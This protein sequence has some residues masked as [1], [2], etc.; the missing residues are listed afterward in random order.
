V[1]ELD[2]SNDLVAS[3][4]YVHGGHVPFLM[5]R[6]G[7]TYRLVTDPVGSVRLVVDTSDGSIAQR[8]DYDP[9][10]VPDYSGPEAAGFVPFGFAGGHHDQATG[11]V[12]MGARDYDPETGRFTA[13]DP[14]GFAGGYASLYAY[15]GGDPVNR[16]DPSGLGPGSDKPQFTSTIGGGFGLTGFGLSGGISL[17]LATEDG[18]WVPQ[19]LL[20]FSAGRGQ[21][22]G[23][24]PSA[25]LGAAKGGIDDQKG[26]GTQV[27]GSGGVLGKGGS[28]IS[29]DTQGRPTGSSVS[30]GTGGGLETHEQGTFT[31]GFNEAIAEAIDFWLAP[32]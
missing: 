14:I 16:A 4:A 1:A 13:K 10:G 28:D 15:V 24:G 23:G 17:V 18:N 9:F 27:G 22:I 3:F 5:R 32:K 21:G 26:F 30:V 11:L 12:R 8:I 2:G 7:T 20:Q 25:T 6:G 29:F 19:L 31:V